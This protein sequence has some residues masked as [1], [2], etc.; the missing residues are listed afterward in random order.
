MKIERLVVHGVETG[1]TQRR[2]PDITLSR[3]PI[4]GLKGAMEGAPHM[5][6]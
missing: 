6:K 1:T 2:L 5:G 4:I 3:F